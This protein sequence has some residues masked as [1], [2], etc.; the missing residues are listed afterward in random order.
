MAKDKGLDLGI[1]LMGSGDKSSADMACKA[2][3]KAIKADD[4]AGFKAAFKDA[5]KYSKEDETASE[6]EPVEADSDMDE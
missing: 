3:W 5:V 1:L 4:Y 2:M 6:D